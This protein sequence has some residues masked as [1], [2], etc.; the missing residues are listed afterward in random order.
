M[1]RRHF[2]HA[3][4][5]GAWAACNQR[6]RTAESRTDP[7]APSRSS[8]SNEDPGYAIQRG[9][10]N[11]VVL[12]SAIAEL[13][14]AHVVLRDPRTLAV[15]R[16]IAVERPLAIGALGGNAFAVLVALDGAVPDAPRLLR[17]ADRADPTRHRFIGGGRLISTETS[18][19]LW[20]VTRNVASRVRF[21]PAALRP[22][23][24]VSLDGDPFAVVCGMPDG[25]LVSHVSGGLLRTY[26]LRASQRY[27]ID[28]DAWHLCAAGA[29][30]V[31]ATHNHEQLVQIQLAPTATIIRTHRLA[32][33]KPIHMHAAG[34]L[35]AVLLVDGDPMHIRYSLAVYDGAVQRWRA[36]VPS[37]DQRSLFVTVSPDRII[38]SGPGVFHGWDAATGRPV[39]S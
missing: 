10:S 27:A 5:L 4:P 14:A 36:P 30:R 11:V 24:S 6:R 13:T 3:L 21:E 28:V 8:T 16:R 34:E 15:T 12:R 23:D 31:W 2:L 18:D 7:S 19:E 26:A 22:V 17:F 37:T 32:P 29:D 38:V 35:A 1:R 9:M 39:T 33:G 20:L 25:S